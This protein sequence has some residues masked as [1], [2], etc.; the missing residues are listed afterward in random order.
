[1][2]NV[3]QIVDRNN[4]I[5]VEYAELSRESFKNLTKKN[6]VSFKDF[7][8]ITP[9]HPEFEEKVALYDWRESLMVGDGGS[10][11]DHSPS[12]KAGMI[13]HWEL[14]KLQGETNRRFMIMEHDAWLIKGQEENFCNLATY[15]WN[16]D[17]PY[18]NVG[19]FMGCYSYSQHCANWMYQLLQEQGFWINGG[20]YGV[21]ERLF[22]NYTD[23]YLKKRNFLDKRHTVIH[24]WMGLRK[25]GMGRNIHPFYNQQE[26]MGVDHRAQPRVP[27]TQVIKK[28][29]SVTQDHHRYDQDLKDEP[30]KRSRQ[31]HV[32]D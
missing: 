2:I 1:M 13:S 24:P 19:L 14:M 20:P 23:H 5:S 26:I 17:I 10:K 4:P 9:D 22:K 8:A 12:E 27:T 28:S 32:I 18:A 6:L 29:L 7:P 25:I 16:Q 21:V 3:L 15:A 11:L 30:W 31:F